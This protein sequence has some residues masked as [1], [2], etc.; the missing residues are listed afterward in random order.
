ML[1]YSKNN[2]IFA[3]RMEGKE[4]IRTYPLL[5]AQMSVFVGWEIHPTATAWNLPSVI[6]FPKTV[7]ADRLENVMSQLAQRQELHIR[8]VKGDD[9]LPRQ[10]IDQQMSIP[11]VRKQLTDEEAT[12]YMNH[13]FVR[14]FTPYGNEPLCRI[15]IIET[16]TRLLLLT[17][18]H[19]TIADGTSIV[20]LMN[21]NITSTSFPT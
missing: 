8:F 1:G 3:S 11:V 6:T 12:A 9:G 10:F 2:R 5:Q 7:S 13:D 17:D 14:P 19:H 18:F 16:P 15:E 21:A 4:T 20:Q